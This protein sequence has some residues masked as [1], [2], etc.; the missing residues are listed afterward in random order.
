MQQIEHRAS[1]VYKRCIIINKQGP[2]AIR[3]EGDQFLLHCATGT[4]PTLD[5]P[6]CLN[7]KD[8]ELTFH[9]FH[10]ISRML[11]SE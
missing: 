8:R 5:L 11:L 6:L 9:K 3:E 4:V 10:L 1:R 2:D 7:L